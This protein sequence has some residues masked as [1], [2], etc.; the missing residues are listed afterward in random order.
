M[1]RSAD[2]EMLLREDPS[3]AS[4]FPI[5]YPDIDAFGVRAERA[6]WV[7]QE[8]Q[9][10]NDRTDWA[11]LDDNVRQF[12]SFIL[13]FFAEAEDV[14][15]DNL[16]HW[17]HASVEVPECKWFF[18]LQIG[19]ETI[20]WRQYGLIIDALIDDDAEKDRLF[21]AAR[22]VPVIRNKSDWARKYIQDDSLSFG[23]RLAAAVCV[24]GI[25]FSSSF[26]AIYWVK[27]N[28]NKLD[29]I[30]QANELIARDE[31]LHQEFCTYLLNHYCES[32]PSS[33]ELSAMVREAAEI[34]KAFVMESL[35]VDLVGMRAT[36]MAQYVEYVADRVMADLGEEPIYG[37]DNPFQRLMRIM[38]AP[39]KTNF[40]ENEVTEYTRGEAATTTAAAAA[41]DDDDNW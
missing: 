4:F 31:G 10:K 26:A 36:K 38:S 17:L 5:K 24:E 28:L 27:V 25:F 35:R 19:V 2:P 1:A 9:L 3:R 7:T 34:E 13:A 30:C 6:I 41:D 32:R 11:T 8:V 37:T 14:V 12:I 16:V 33:A 15:V 18:G 20:H 39:T 23:T 40:F 22:N 21:R 29:G